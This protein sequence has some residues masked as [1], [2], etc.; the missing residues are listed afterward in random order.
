MPYTSYVED[1]NDQPVQYINVATADLP[2]GV[3][4]TYVDP[5]TLGTIPA[6][7]YRITAAASILNGAVGAAFFNTKVMVGAVAYAPGETS[8]ITSGSC[9]VNTPAFTIN[10]PVAAVVKL[11][12]TGTQLGTVK[13]VGVNGGGVA[14]TTWIS[15]IR[16]K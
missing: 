5:V 10:I 2:I 7:T 13:Y 8:C 15:A 3:I 6:G 14:G 1:P 9:Q 4:G 16:I 12:C 11:S